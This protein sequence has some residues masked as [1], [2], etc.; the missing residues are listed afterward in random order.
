M[1]RFL[2]SWCGVRAM[3]LVPLPEEEETLTAY[4]KKQRMKKKEEAEKDE[5]DS[6]A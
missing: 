4:K 3:Q 6:E 5:K 1:D 2:K